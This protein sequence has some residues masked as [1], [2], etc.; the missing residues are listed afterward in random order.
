MY[1]FNYLLT[2]NREKAQGV[3]RKRIV[4]LVFIL[5]FFVSIVF[6]SLLYIN[7]S[8]LYLKNESL[9]KEKDKINKKLINFRKGK[10]FFNNKNI[11]NVYKIQENRVLWTDVFY[12]LEMLLGE[13]AIIDEVHYNFDRLVVKCKLKSEEETTKAEISRLLITY[14]DSLNNSKILKKY[15]SEDV[16]ISDGPD[17]GAK[18]KIKNVSAFLW[19]FEFAMEFKS[20]LRFNNKG[21]KNKKRKS[22]FN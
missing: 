9:I 1:K 17:K 10:S 18:T 12:D 4:N 20:V 16:V 2:I 15:L 7:T 6:L 22:R 3:Q 21:K 13:R 14:K 8:N 5:S 19:S 11:A